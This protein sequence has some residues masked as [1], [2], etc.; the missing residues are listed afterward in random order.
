MGEHRTAIP[1]C[2][3]RGWPRRRPAAPRQL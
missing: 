2:A 3:S 1:A